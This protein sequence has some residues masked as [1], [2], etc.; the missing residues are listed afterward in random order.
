MLES[1]NDLIGWDILLITPYK[2]G[3]K[4]L[5]ISKFLEGKFII[6]FCPE[7]I[8]DKIILEAKKSDSD[9]SLRNINTIL[10][11]ESL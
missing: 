6:V 9:Y 4:Q 10:K 11:E 1:P 3:V 7:D 8:W 2:L 5:H